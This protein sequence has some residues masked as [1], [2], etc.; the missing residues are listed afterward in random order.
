MAKGLV[1]INTG[2]GKGKTTAA[3]GTAI[4]AVGHGQKVA[5]LQFMKSPKTGEG[6]FLD[7]YAKA[8]PDRLLHECFGLGFI[9]GEPSAAD[10]AEARK[11]FE[12]AQ[13]ILAED[14]DLVVLDEICVALS[15]GMLTVEEVTALINNRCPI[16]NLILTGRGC[17]EAIIDLAD[18]VTEMTEI[19]HAYQKGIKARKGVEF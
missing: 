8:H 14:F 16:T 7:V 5:V 10:L 18:T 17:P 6:H 2:P 9:M 3:L 13:S 19:K 1:L 4:R 15:M 12:R 11:A